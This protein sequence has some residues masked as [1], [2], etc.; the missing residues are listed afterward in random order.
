[1][2]FPSCF[3]LLSVLFHSSVCCFRRSGWYVGTKCWPFY[4]AR[5]TLCVH[6]CAYTQDN[7]CVGLCVQVCAACTLSTWTVVAVQ[8]SLCLLRACLVY[9]SQATCAN[10]D[11]KWVLLTKECARHYL[12]SHNGQAWC[13]AYSS[14][15]DAVLLDNHEAQLEDVQISSESVQKEVGFLLLSSS[16]WCTPSLFSFSFL[17]ALSLSPFLPHPSYL[18]RSLLCPFSSL[19]PS[20]FLFHHSL[21]FPLSVSLFHTRSHTFF[22][23]LPFSVRFLFLFLWHWLAGTSALGDGCFPN[24]FSSL[25]SFY[26]FFFSGKG[27]EGW[28]EKEEESENVKRYSEFFFFFV[29]NCGHSKARLAGLF[30]HGW[31]SLSRSVLT[32]LGTEQRKKKRMRGHLLYM[33]TAVMTVVYLRALVWWFHWFVHRAIR[34]AVELLKV[35]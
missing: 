5:S 22:S 16:C 10:D 30:E 26:V 18:S 19:S 29:F 9:L 4:F 11:G 32:Q 6:M 21:P 1:M 3:C 31:N 34:Y 24:L 14:A 8:S 33:M 7:V 12:P 35:V 13:L 28:E 17:L 15:N 2:C 23:L 25:F 27:R 20:L